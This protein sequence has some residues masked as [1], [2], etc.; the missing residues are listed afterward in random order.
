MEE[1]LRHV[2]LPNDMTLF[3]GLKPNDAFYLSKFKKF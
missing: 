2:Q 1:N 3:K